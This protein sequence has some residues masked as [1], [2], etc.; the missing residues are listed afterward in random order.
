[1]DGLRPV[2]ARRGG[3]DLRRGRARRGAHR[4]HQAHR[5]GRSPALGDDPRR[6]RRRRH[7]PRSRGMSGRTEAGNAITG[8]LRGGR[9]IGWGTALPDQ[10]MSNADLAAN[11][12]TSD[13]WITERTGIK[14]RRYGGTTAGLAAAAGGKAGEQ[15]G[16]EPSSIDL[17][18]LCTTS[19]DRNLPASASRVQDRKSKRLNSSH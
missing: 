2:A 16:V 8:G 17:L 11:L 4:H 19:P 15:A 12:D 9:I 18:I 6:A 13:A 1:M 3:D 10:V 14:E 7:R 5:Q